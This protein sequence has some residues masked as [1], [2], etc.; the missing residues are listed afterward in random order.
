[1]AEF[2][3]KTS[4]VQMCLTKRR[5]KRAEFVLSKVNVSHGMTI[6]DVGCGPN[7]RSFEDFI[8]K[9]I[10]ITGI[11]ILDETEVKTNNPSFKYLKQDAQDLKIFSDNEFELAVSFG[12]MEHICDHSVLSKMSSEI[13]RVSKQWVIVVPWKCAFIEPHFKFPFFQL[14]PY[15]LKIFLTKIL[16]LHNL[17]KKVELD[18]NYITKHYQWL[19]NSQWVSIFKGAR[20]YVTPHLDTIA[21]V[22]TD[23]MDHAV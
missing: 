15:S 3:Y 6:L 17:K 23:T 9:D 1:M 22:K 18:Y 10:K 5:Q 12:M 8:S 4:L 14:L 11:D 16:N 7:G 2:F 21:I 13:S 19:T 20:C